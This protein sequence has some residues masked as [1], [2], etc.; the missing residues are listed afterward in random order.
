MHN[1]CQRHAELVVLLDHSTGDRFYSACPTLAR[2]VNVALSVA[3]STGRRLLS[4]NDAV[5]V[6]KAIRMGRRIAESAS[7]RGRAASRSLLDLSGADSPSPSPASGDGVSAV[8]PSNV[9][10]TPAEVKETSLL[11]A[12]LASVYRRVFE[13]DASGDPMPADLDEYAWILTEPNAH[14]WLV[15]WL[16]NSDRIAE[17][18]S[19]NCASEIIQDPQ[20]REYRWWVD[21]DERD[22]LDS[23]NTMVQCV[24][25]QCAYDQFAKDYKSVKLA[26]DPTFGREPDCFT[27]SGHFIVTSPACATAYARMF[28]VT[29]ATLL[30]SVAANVNNIQDACSDVTTEMTARNQRKNRWLRRRTLPSR[31]VVI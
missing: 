2:L 27:A 12:G 9:C 14:Q 19:T 26:C 13:V 31:Q 16:D 23:D 18:I 5:E 3:L 30:V 21:L 24:D 22:A 25:T 4:Q 10:P 8:I 29:E 28:N 6:N 1:K 15:P 20:A 7:E 11:L 17:Y